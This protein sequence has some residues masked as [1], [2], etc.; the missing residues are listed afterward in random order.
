MATSACTVT[1][2]G[3]V[4]GVGF[5]P[6][7]Y[8]LARANTLAGW[9][10]NGDEGVEI[11]VEG[12]RERVDAFLREL[13]TDAPVSAS[14]TDIAVA[15]AEP[16]GLEGF[17]IRASRSGDQ[18]RVPISPD[19]ALCA[20][21]LRELFAPTD[22]RFHYPYI[23][24]TDCGPR[25]SIVTR[26][27]YD[28]VSTTMAA[29]TMDPPCE[30]EYHDPASRR[31]HA[32][33]NACPSCGPG[34]MLIEGDQVVGAS[35]EPIARAAA[36]LRNGRI[37]AVKGLGGYHLACDARNPAAVG[38]LRDRKYRKEKPFAL[39]ARGRS[40]PPDWRAALRPRA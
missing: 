25:Y 29:W 11:R 28:R 3:V 35:A 31:F 36:L 21:C 12:A 34:M 6:F 33:P 19:L 8:R 20:R 32:Q 40:V 26:V 27:P 38:A 39:M 30:R 13:R 5:R 15:V 4:Q 17:V 10:L 1:V 9:V 14:I 2:R 18:P 24:C 16:S 37:L 23:N 22:R 7:V